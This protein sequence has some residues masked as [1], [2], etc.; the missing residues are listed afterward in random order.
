MNI[1]P[2]TIKDSLLILQEISCNDIKTIVD[3]D[4]HDSESEDRWPAGGSPFQKWYRQNVSVSTTIHD[5]KDRC[6]IA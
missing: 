1:I 4:F 6:L 3:E 2:A 5:E